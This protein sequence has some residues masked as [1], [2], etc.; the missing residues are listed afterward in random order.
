MPRRD[1]EPQ[2]VALD[3]TAQRSGEHVNVLDRVRAVDAARSGAQ[4]VPG[5]GALPAAAA[6]AEKRRAAEDVAAV[7]QT[8]FMRMP[9]PE[10]S[11]G[12]ALVMIVIS[13]CSMSSKYACDAPSRL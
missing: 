7:F 3:G 11:A 13:D 5:V 1:Q 8:L 12:M 4:L 2:F 10:V 9:P 6:E